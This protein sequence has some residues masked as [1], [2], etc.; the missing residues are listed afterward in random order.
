MGNMEG[1][2][3]PAW[4]SAGCVWRMSRPLPLDVHVLC[5]SQH[6]CRVLLNTPGL[7]LLG[8]RQSRL[9][10]RRRL[11]ILWAWFSGRVRSRGGRGVLYSMGGWIQVGRGGGGRG[12]CLRYVAVEWGGGGAGWI[13]GGLVGSSACG[14]AYGLFSI[15]NAVAFIRSDALG[16]HRIPAFNWN[17]TT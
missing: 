17:T 4:G 16:W 14:W 11:A 2:P 1:L 13:V 5:A 12:G 10:H 9:P 3:C 6:H 7:V 8:E 15:L